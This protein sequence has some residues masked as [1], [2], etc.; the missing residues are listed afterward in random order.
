MGPEGTAEASARAGRVVLLLG[1]AR[2]GK[3]S[4]AETLAGALAGGRAVVYIATAQAGD[5][6]MRARIARHRAARPSGWITIEAP[7]DPAS[8]LSASKEAQEARV[9]LLDCVTLLASNLLLDA[10]GGDGREPS[11]EDA[12]RRIW[13]ALEALLATCRR[14]GRPLVL[15]SN[16]VGMGIVPPYPIGRVYRDALGQVNTRLAQEADAVLL[17][18]AG[19]PVEIKALSAAWRAEAAR[20]L[21]LDDR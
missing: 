20:R 13:S 14:M 8:A 12:A 16:E 5:E 21:G 9:V 17:L 7:L 4:Y 19:L 1:G 18:V 11:A 3:S 6:E 10:G 2:S 15:V